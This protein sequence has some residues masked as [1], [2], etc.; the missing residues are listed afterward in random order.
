MNGC[1]EEG[2]SDLSNLFFLETRDLW[3]MVGEMA[4]MGYVTEGDARGKGGRGMGT[5]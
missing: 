5:P 4:F 3:E 2:T 1:L